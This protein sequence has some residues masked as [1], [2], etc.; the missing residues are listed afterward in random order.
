MQEV[1]PLIP[2]LQSGGAKAEASQ[3]DACVHGRAIERVCCSERC[4]SA[5]SEVLPVSAA[6]AVL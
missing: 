1:L 2:R 6:I 5:D 4:V 3:R